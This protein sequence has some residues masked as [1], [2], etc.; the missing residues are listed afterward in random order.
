MSH[1][2]TAVK[3]AQIQIGPIKIDKVTYKWPGNT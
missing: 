3:T 1:G 2:K